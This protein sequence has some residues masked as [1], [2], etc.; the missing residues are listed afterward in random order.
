[1]IRVGSCTR[2]SKD[3]VLPKYPNFKPIFCLTKS[4]PY[5]S[6]G[7][8]CLF[9]EEGYCMENIWQFSKVYNNVPAQHIINRRNGIVEWTYPYVKMLDDEG[10]ITDD[11]KIWRETGFKCKY[12]IRYPAGFNNR[13]NCLYALETINS[14][15]KLDY[16]QSRKRIYY[17]VYKKLVEKQPQFAELKE[18]LARGENLLIIE[19]DGPVQS[20]LDYYKEKYNVPDNFIEGDSSLMTQE[21]LNIFINDPKN[22]F[23]HGYCLAGCLLDIASF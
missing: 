22:P 15:E 11:Y 6:L 5:G 14:T 7:P 13:K 9:T 21:S 10:N 3:R 4:T 17:P 2:S 8:Y 20:D 19:V 18:R 23:G 1:M 12:P 16:I